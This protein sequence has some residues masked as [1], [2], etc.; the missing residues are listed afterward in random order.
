MYEQHPIFL[1]FSNNPCPPAMYIFC[2]RNSLLA[3]WGLWE[4]NILGS[5]WKHT[6]NVQSKAR[7]LMRE[8]ISICCVKQRERNLT[9]HFF[10]REGLSQIDSP[11]DLS[12]T[13]QE[14]SRC[15]SPSSSPR[16]QLLF[17][18]LSA[19]SYFLKS[20]H[21]ITTYH[22]KTPRWGLWAVGL[23]S[24]GL[25]PCVWMNPILEKIYYQTT[26]WNLLFTYPFHSQEWTI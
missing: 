26:V 7:P 11:P 22:R 18:S 9:S 24:R 14:T 16:C 12:R 1:F 8:K 21:L 3:S 20:F 6:C 15:L 23:L 19:L 17:L 10:A 13:W 2:V 25:F 5:C 4:K